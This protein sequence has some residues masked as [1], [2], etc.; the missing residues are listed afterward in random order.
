MSVADQSATWQYQLGNG[1]GNMTLHGQAGYQPSGCNA[2]VSSLVAIK[3]SNAMYPDVAIG[4][5]MEG[6]ASIC[7]RMRSLVPQRST[8]RRELKRTYCGAG[9]LYRRRA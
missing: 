6:S 4:G 3:L 7:G 1:T 5:E 9:G 8:L 2:G